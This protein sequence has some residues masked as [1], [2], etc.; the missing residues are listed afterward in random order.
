MSA[1]S[2]RNRCMCGNSFGMYGELPEEN[3]DCP[4]RGDPSQKCGCYLS[5]LVYEVD[6]VSDTDLS[7]YF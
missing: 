7:F 2:L 5:N 4:C 1:I 6:S 3:C